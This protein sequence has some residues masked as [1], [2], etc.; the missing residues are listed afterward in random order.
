MPQ[1]L[2]VRRLVFGW[3]SQTCNWFYVGSGT[4][5]CGA[6][7]RTGKRGGFLLVDRRT[8]ELIPWISADGI[9]LSVAWFMNDASKN[10]MWWN[11]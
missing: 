11:E 4:N 6:G 7:G 9:R 10:G 1:R 5:V 3:L 8:D 2:V